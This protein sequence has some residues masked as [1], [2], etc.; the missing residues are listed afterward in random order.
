MTHLRAF[1]GKCAGR[2]MEVPRPVCFVV[3]GA[4]TPEVMEALAGF[5]PAHTQTKDGFRQKKWFSCRS[6]AVGGLALFKKSKGEN[7]GM[8]LSSNIKSGRVFAT[9]PRLSLAVALLFCFFWAI[10]QAAGADSWSGR[11]GPDGGYIGSAAVDPTDPNTA[12]ATNYAGIFKTTNGG[13]SWTN[14]NANWGAGAQILIDPANHNT[15]Y[16]VVGEIVKSVDGGANWTVLD[17]HTSCN[18]HVETLVIDPKNTSTLYA[19]MFSISGS[20]VNYYVIK[21]SDGGGNWTQLAWKAQTLA[22]DPTNSSILYA[23]DESGLKKSTDGGATWNPA[24]TGLPGTGTVGTAVVDP[25]TPATLYLVVDAS[26]IYKST[27]GG[28]LWVPSIAGIS[29]TGFEDPVID[30]V[31]P[32]NLYLIAQSSTNLQGTIYKSSNGAGQWT[33]L[34]LGVPTAS[35]RVLA[36]AASSPATLY[37]GTLSHGILKSTDGG[38]AWTARNNGLKAWATRMVLDPTNK[39]NLYL[40]INGLGVFQSTDGGNNW[41]SRNS[42]L[43]SLLVQGLA[44]SPANPQI[45]YVSVDSASIL[46]LIVMKIPLPGIFKST[47]GG[48][49][50]TACSDP[51]DNFGMQA[52]QAL[53]ADPANVNGLYALGFS[54]GVY[55]TTDGGSSWSVSKSG[56]PDAIFYALAVDPKIPANLYVG[57][58]GTSGVT[59]LVYKSADSGAT[60]N[61]SGSGLPNVTGVW[62]LA[63]D[64]KTPSTLYAAL[65]AS[66]T[67]NGGV[68]KSTNGGG[69]WTDANQGISNFDWNSYYTSYY[70]SIHYTSILT[71]CT[72][73]QI[74]ISATALAVDPTAPAT[75]FAVVNGTVFRSTDGA[76]NW[77]VANAGLLFTLNQI[78]ISPADHTAVYGASLG[79]YVFNASG[80]GGGTS[81]LTVNAP[82]GS[83]SWLVGSTQNI[84]WAATGT[85]GNVKIEISTD[86]GSNYSTLVASTAN[87]GSYS[88][89]IPNTP[90]ATCKVRLSD[91]AGTVSDTSD[92][93][94]TLTAT[95]AYSLNSINV[96]FNVSGGIGNLNVTAAG[97]G[98]AWTAAS[99][100]AWIT[101]TSGASG[102]GSGTVNYSVAANGTPSSRTGTLTIAG[103]TFTVTQ[104][105]TTGSTSIT[106]FVPIVLSVNGA[107]GSFYTTELTLAN[108]GNTAAEVEFEYTGAAN[109]GG[110]SGKAT[111]SLPVGQT[112]I[113]NSI[114]YL[115]S[116]G[117]AI[118]DSGNRGGTLRIHF[119]NLSSSSV[120]SVTARTSTEVKDGGGNVLGRAGLSYPAIP[121]SAVLTAPAYIGGLRQNSTDRSNV[122]F[123]NAGDSS[124]GSLT[125]QATVFDGNSSFSQVLPA[126]V[127]EPG[128]F[129]QIDRVLAS[130]GLSLTNGY[131]KVERT[132]GTSPYY[133]YGVI[134]DQV[135]SDGSF[136]APQPATS[137]PVA[138]LTLP[139][140][141]QTSTLLSEVVLTN[142]SN[143][144]RSVNFAYADTSAH[145]TIDLQPGQQQIIQD[146]FA[147]M[148]DH[149]VPGIGPA[150]TTIVG[151]LFAT[152]AGGDLSGVILSARTSFS[153]GSAGGRFGLAYMAVPVG[154]TS[155][156]SAWLFGLQQNSENRTNLAIVN[157]GEADGNSDSFVIDLYDG[158]TG[159]KVKTMDPINLNAHGWIQ[160]GTI[161]A[162]N[163]P[164]VLQGFAQVRRTSG[165]NP[166]VT[167]A[168][169]NDGAGA[170]LRTG[171]GAYIG[172]SSD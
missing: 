93:N 144:T 33:A 132:S 2:Y 105:G 36:L 168:V 137:T 54:A 4:P 43:P 120:A 41:V 44:I 53:A 107:G 7:H 131:V 166:F 34:N 59:N 91:V 167:Y 133:A 5:S 65:L 28:G 95:C 122:A 160:L 156:N 15:L 117:I 115:K 74:I 76:G 81:S 12:Y 147:Y 40:G 142:W 22:V 8:N 16:V 64:P 46:D 69:R 60:W 63:I 101:I 139:V 102:S 20:T 98:C 51:S 153:G 80:G 39:N 71:A 88:W 118:P 31:N 35:A 94:F 143:Q 52:P 171:D 42:G 150:G 165:N 141:V 45:L 55:R 121:L 158:A 58:W 62:D 86:G 79:L 48:L 6:A 124:D 68:F 10:P 26:S 49:N 82:N 152:A 27:N 140:I 108:R 18:D 99:N 135:N 97:G 128:G 77:G 67:I 123:Q 13:A 148:R 126:I 157:T 127:L 155:S 111:I 119:S 1:G 169:I 129:F 25:Q 66:E 56:L 57:L 19:L 29:G 100:V 70:S 104:A 23:G 109:L 11:G 21:S 78:G 89:T 145:F 170:G 163:A 116:L 90:S 138:G 130:N 14:L 161:L 3:C 61:P 149:S 32:A 112:V 96:S 83:E 134:N 159:T 47:N 136:V 151:A 172:S 17:T 162:N 114:T 24:Q 30:P 73:A 9:I 37:A 164:G 38:T 110:G 106:Q 85:V 146:I 154:Q 84:T 92:G 103:Q 125:L 72:P 50:W 113:S 75:L 87:T